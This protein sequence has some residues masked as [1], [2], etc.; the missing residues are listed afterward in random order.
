MRIARFETLR[1]RDI[2]KA[3]PGNIRMMTITGPIDHHALRTARKDAPEPR[4]SDDGRDE[5]PETPLDEPRPQP[6]KDPPAEPDKGPYVAALSLIVVLTS[7]MVACAHLGTPSKNNVA[8]RYVTAQGRL[9]AIRRAQVW[10]PTNVASMDVRQGPAADDGF[11]PNESVTCNYTEKKMSGRSPKFACLLGPEDQVKVKYGRHNGEVYAEV[12]ATRLFWALG[13][14]SDRVYPV[15]VICRGCP[16]SIQDTALATIQ[17][18]IGK[19]IETSDGS[20]W[21]WKE[22]DLVDPGAGGAPRAQRDALKL[23][24]V[25]IQHTDSKPEQQRL[26]CLDKGEKPAGDQCEQTFM[27]V[28]DLGQT[29]G[30]ANTFNRNSVGSVNLEN[31]A[32]A[33]VWA[34]S[35]GCVANLPKSWTGS[36]EN[37]P[38]TEEGRK[39]LAD[40]LAQLTDAQL[41]ALFEV[42]RFPQRVDAAGPAAAAMIDRWV[43]AFKAKRNDIV[44]RSCA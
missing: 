1:W 21:A 15:Q 37:P 23:L 40:L 31:W 35:K 44:Q 32:K 33:P 16:P 17:R 43:E 2:C 27:I 42:S 41:H 7:S 22:L 26:I 3:A 28:H 20:G 14:A 30:K 13:F 4:P 8:G 24:A 10:S 18:K 34:D 5:A 38:I 12:A 9:A 11:K 36:L 25:F 39:F 6:V 19:D 29:F